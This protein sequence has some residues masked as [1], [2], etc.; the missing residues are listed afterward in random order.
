MK[1]DW[2]EKGILEW[3]N[4]MKKMSYS[5]F[6]EKLQSYGHQVYEAGVE[7]GESTGSWWTDVEI[8]DLLRSERIGAERA[9]RIVEKLVEGHEDVRSCK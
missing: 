7:E 5:Q 4:K 9:Q 3:F 1:T 8:F 6:L 2:N